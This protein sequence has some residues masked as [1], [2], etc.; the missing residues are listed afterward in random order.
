LKIEKP[1]DRISLHLSF[2][3][4][5]APLDYA[6]IIVAPVIKCGRFSV[7][8]SGHALRDLDARAVRQVVLLKI[9]L[10][11]NLSRGEKLILNLHERVL[12]YMGTESSNPPR[13]ATESLTN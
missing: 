1:S 11:R 2:K 5:P 10:K 12:L 3:S 7:G 6:H 4:L 8:V 13:S 9:H